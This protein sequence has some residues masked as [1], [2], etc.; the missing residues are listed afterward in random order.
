M[1]TYIYIHTQQV[2]TSVFELQLL[3]SERLLE[4]KVNMPFDTDPSSL[5]VPRLPWKRQNFGGDCLYLRGKLV[6]LGNM[7]FCVLS[8]AGDVLNNFS[9]VHETP[10]LCQERIVTD[11]FPEVCRVWKHIPKVSRT[12]EQREKGKHH[13]DHAALGPQEEGDWSTGSVWWEMVK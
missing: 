10:Q 9:V 3:R 13:G 4:E 12:S 7:P 11:R 1:Y 5:L 2:V 8:Q 6:F